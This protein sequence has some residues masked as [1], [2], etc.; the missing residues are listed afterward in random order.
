VL[1]TKTAR[2]KVWRLYTITMAHESASSRLYRRLKEDI[3]I[4][5][6]PPGQSFSEAEFAKRYKI[7]RTPVRETC[8]LLQN[9]SL[10]TIIPFRGYFVAPLT[11]FE[12]RDLQEVQL[13]SDPTAAALAAQRATS[14][15]VSRLESDAKHGYKVGSKSSFYE[16]LQW[17][18]RLHVGIA[19][20][21]GNKELAAIVASVH[22]RLMRYFYPGLSLDEFGPRL[23]AEHCLIVEAIRKRDAEKAR[24]RAKRHILNTKERSFK[25]VFDLAH[26]HLVEQERNSTVFTPPASLSIARY[27]HFG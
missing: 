19:Q 24:R 20:S 12:F 3:I 9:E 6:L 4:G 23:V 27:G 17:N 15:Q 1:D 16:F 10:I 25:L 18:F 5:A 13:M 21:T 22:T 11:A 8:R 2:I 7:S 14:E 26:A